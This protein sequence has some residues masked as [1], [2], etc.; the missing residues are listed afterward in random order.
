MP[1]MSTR[2]TIIGA[3]AIRASSPIDISNLSQAGTAVVVFL[4][5]GLE[6]RFSRIALYSDAIMVAAHN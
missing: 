2:A 3:A 5:A 4:V 6:L 1:T